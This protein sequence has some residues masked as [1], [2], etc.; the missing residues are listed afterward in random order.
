[1]KPITLCLAC[2]FLLLEYVKAQD[3]L[4][5]AP[6]QTHQALLARITFS[7]N[8]SIKVHIMNIKDSAV[9]V[10]DKAKAKPDPFHTTNIYNESKWDSYNYR[11]IESIMVRNK[12]LRSWLLPVSIVG[13]MVVG[14]L[15][16]YAAARK[17]GGIEDDLNEAGGIVLGGLL[18][19]GV[20]TVTGLVICGS[21][22]KKYLINGDWKS[23][24]EMKRSMNY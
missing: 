19:A 16:G 6:T 8:Q 23:F 1:M 3:S 17:S 2:S 5:Y 9:F 21:S 13:G 11:F 7:E 10:Y 15:I 14:A 18:G 22:D 12:K 20:G 4:K 24:E